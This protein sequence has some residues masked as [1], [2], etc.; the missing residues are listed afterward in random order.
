MRTERDGVGVLVEP[1]AALE[2]RVHETRK[3]RAADLPLGLRA[4]AVAQVRAHLLE[5][6]VELLQCE[7][8]PLDGVPRRAGAEAERVAIGLEPLRAGPERPEAVRVLGYLC[9]AQAEPTR[10]RAEPSVTHL[11]RRTGGP[12]AVAEAGL[13]RPAGA[14]VDLVVSRGARR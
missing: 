6:V 10:R 1:D 14:K 3:G 5:H 12:G 11:L 2:Q 4:I 9:A 13:G 8:L 7:T